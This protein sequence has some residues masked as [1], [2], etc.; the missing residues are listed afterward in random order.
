M[1]TA[2]MLHVLDG[3]AKVVRV[4][5]EV[6]EADSSVPGPPA[7]CVQL[8]EDGL[9]DELHAVLLRADGNVLS[10][11]DEK[12]FRFFS[13]TSTFNISGSGKKSFRQ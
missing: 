10:H 8:V 2:E 4:E 9:D 12:I 7:L 13:C 5:G 3:S 11:P 6:E 1:P